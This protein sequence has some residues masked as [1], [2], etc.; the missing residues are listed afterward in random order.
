MLRLQLRSMGALYEILI[1]V[2][3]LASSTFDAFRHDVLA[4]LVPRLL[5]TMLLAPLV[6]TQT[7]LGLGSITGV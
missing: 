1:F 2:N 3:V 5:V 7:G 6:A 4:L